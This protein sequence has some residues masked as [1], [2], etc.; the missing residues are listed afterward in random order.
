MEKNKLE[1][2]SHYAVIVIA[3]LAFILSIL[4]TRIQ[5]DHNKLSVRPILN[6]IIEQGDSLSL[7]YINNKG[8]GPAIIKKVSFTYQGKTYN[9]IEK[10]LRESGLY[11]IRMGGYTLHPNTV[12]SANEERLLVKLKGRELK[13][14]KVQLFYESVYEEVYDITFTF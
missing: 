11:K 10:L 14:V 12:I 4:Q 2:L 3:L 8:V 9:D 5:H 6:S 13:G 1:T 7:A